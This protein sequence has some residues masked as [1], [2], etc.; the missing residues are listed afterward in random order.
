MESCWG[1]GL[2]GI[3]ICW[4]EERGPKMSWEGDA[5]CL[6]YL[7]Q[8]R[9]LCHTSPSGGDVRQHQSAEGPE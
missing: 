2:V 9:F 7:D 6:W 5:Q 4:D 8:G 1:K 3:N